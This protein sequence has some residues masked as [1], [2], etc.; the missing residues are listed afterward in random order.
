LPLRDLCAY[1]GCAMPQ[2]APLPSMPEKHARLVAFLVK[3]M[4]C[5]RAQ[6]RPG[7]PARSGA[8]SRLAPRNAGEA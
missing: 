4:V 3:A 1:P 8:S 5:P 2:F 6:S 7:T